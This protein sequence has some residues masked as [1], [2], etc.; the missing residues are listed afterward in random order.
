MVPFFIFGL[1]YNLFWM[2]RH[3]HTGDSLLAPL[4]AVLWTTVDGRPVESA[5]WFL[6]V[7]FWAWLIYTLI[8]KFVKNTWTKVFLLI[9][10]SAIG[11]LWGSVL[12]FR[13]PWGIQDALAVQMFFLAG[14]SYRQL[15]E[16]GSGVVK[17]WEALGGKRKLCFLIVGILIDALMI[18]KNGFVNIRVGQWPGW[19]FTY[20]NAILAVWLW[21]ELIKCLMKNRVLARVPGY[22]FRR[23]GMYSIVWLCINHPVIRLA[24]LIANAICPHVRFALQQQAVI[25]ILAFAILYAIAEILMHT[26]ARVLFGRWKRVE[27]A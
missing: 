19:I 18:G 3:L 9:V 13:L 21:A 20:V 26:P 1:G 15:E 16:R 4:K 11:C 14:H 5:L 25:V 6:M 23:M 2:C 12:S 10:L 7:L 8:D 22:V 24:K 17:S 27:R